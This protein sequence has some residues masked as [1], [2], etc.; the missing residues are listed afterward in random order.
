[1]TELQPQHE[2][3]QQEGR[4]SAMISVAGQVLKRGFHAVTENI[5]HSSYYAAAQVR[6][7]PEQAGQIVENWLDSVNQAV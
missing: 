1:M 7:Y 4:L 3:P 5:A 6:T 2:K